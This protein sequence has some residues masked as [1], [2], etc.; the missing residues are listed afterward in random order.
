MNGGVGIGQHQLARG[1]TDRVRDFVVGRF[2]H[3]DGA[4]LDADAVARKGIVGVCEGRLHRIHDFRMRRHDVRDVH[5]LHA[6]TQRDEHLGDHARVQV[7]FPWLLVRS[8]LRIHREVEL[9][10]GRFRIEHDLDVADDADGL[11]VAR[12]CFDR[13]ALGL[14][15]GGHDGDRGP[16]RDEPAP[17]ETFRFQFPALCEKHLAGG[18]GMTKQG[19]EQHGEFLRW[20]NGTV[21]LWCCWQKD[22]RNVDFV[23]YTPCFLDLLLCSWEAQIRSNG[24]ILPRPFIKGDAMQN[25]D[26]R[27][28]RASRPNLPALTRSTGEL[29]LREKVVSVEV[30]RNATA[31]AQRTNR[32]IEAVL[33]ASGLVTSDN[34]V[35]LLSRQFNVPSIDLNNVDLQEDAARLV[36]KELCERHA[37]VPVAIHGGKT[38]VVAIANPGNLHAI[39]DLKFRTGMIIDL[40]VAS[41]ENI[42]RV[43]EQLY[44]AIER[45]EHQTAMTR[46]LEE[47]TE[48][49]EITGDETPEVDPK[50]LA[51]SSEEAPVVHLVNMILVDALQRGASDIHIEPYK[52]HVRLRYRIDGILYEMMRPPLKLR[53]A[54]VS[55]IK[56]MCKMD[57]S[58]RRLPQDGRLKMRLVDGKECDFRVSVLPFQYGEKVVMRLL[59]KANLQTDMTRLGFDTAELKKFAYAIHQPF[60]MVLVTGPTGSGKTTTLYSALAEL[61]R[62][63]DNISTAEDP[64]EYDL[65]GIN[66]CQ[67]HDAIGMTFANALRSF[68]RQDPDIIMVGEIRDF[69]TAE[70]AIKAALTGHMVLSTLHT[71][72][73]PSTISRLLNMGVEPFMVTASLNLIAAQRLVRR[74][75][76]HCAVP[77]SYDRV[78]CLE[79][80]LTET[81]YQ[82]ATFLKGG[83][84]D[85]CVKTGYKG[86]VALYEIMPMSDVLRDAVLQGHSVQELKHVAIQDGMQTLRQSALKKFAVGLTTLEEVVRVT[87]AD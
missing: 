69:E 72:D 76:K 9:R 45:D 22:D 57:I 2:D 26:D 7:L 74:V 75:C 11:L 19:E 84:C 66:Q 42:A 44:Q 64:I 28:R 13:E 4:R 18:A 15:G 29:L 63:S 51:A 10:R 73:A 46:Q 8:L 70:I 41:E 53:D 60:G 35:E 86:R 5:V 1:R 77:F 47:M 16:R 24:S 30:L 31:E 87:R 79:A 58:E 38:L 43:R 50:S 27:P 59:D 71:N 33:I 81:E 55:R 21:P 39:E 67:M 49:A 6:I 23:K 61:N 37:M 14:R 17:C 36:P 3:F 52:K 20:L 62:T 65:D 54:I 32:T 34:L 25:D 68:L 82:N 40:V 85:Q 78:A 80:G 48:G 56:I 83:G 12:P